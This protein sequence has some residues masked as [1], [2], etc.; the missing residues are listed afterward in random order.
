M[1][2]FFGKWELTKSSAMIIWGGTIIWIHETV[3]MV[4]LFEGVRLFETSEY[5]DIIFWWDYINQETLK[6]FW[7]AI[8]TA[9]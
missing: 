4:Q 9:A 5:Y 2:E 6:R 3:K 1:Y 8:I 7:L